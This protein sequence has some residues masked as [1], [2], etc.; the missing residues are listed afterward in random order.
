M[1][2]V[3]QRIVARD[4]NWYPGTTEINEM[5]KDYY[6][7]WAVPRARE[8]RPPMTGIRM[9][10][11]LLDRDSLPTCLIRR[12]VLHLP[13]AHPDPDAWPTVAASLGARAT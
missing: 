11:L 3:E 7:A 13:R 1:Q 9:E 10:K 4:F 5:A 6:D 2:F 8:R 12:I